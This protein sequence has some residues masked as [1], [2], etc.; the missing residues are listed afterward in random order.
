MS[1]KQKE[2]HTKLIHVTKI[3]QEIKSS[4]ALS[5]SSRF[6]VDKTLKTVNFERARTIVELGSGNGCVTREILSRMHPEAKLIGFEI[7]DFFFNECKK[8]DDDR[9]IM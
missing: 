2:K 7:S 9:L 1:P 8:I 5:P 4:G 3:I 6:L